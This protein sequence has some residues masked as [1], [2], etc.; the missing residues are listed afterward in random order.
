MY[1]KI[2]F[3]TSATS[4]FDGICAA[5]FC[6]LGLGNRGCCARRTLPSRHDNI[7]SSTSTCTTFFF[8]FLKIF[9]LSF[10][11]PLYSG[12]L[13]WGPQP[14]WHVDRYTAGR[15]RRLNDVICCDLLGEC[16]VY[17]CRPF[18]TSSVLIYQNGTAPL[19]VAENDVTSTVPWQDNLDKASITCIIMLTRM[20]FLCLF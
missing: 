12:T 14:T 5:S 6:L 20:H 16:K 9:S 7:R 8:F 13:T 15:C 17:L 11:L 3:C 18:W 4:V 1:L 19:T 2:N 10:S